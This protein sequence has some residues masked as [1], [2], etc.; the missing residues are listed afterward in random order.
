VE[1]K[2]FVRRMGA[3]E[4]ERERVFRELLPE[5]ERRVRGVCWKQGLRSHES[6]DD[7]L[8]MTVMAMLTHWHAYRGDGSL[9]GWVSRI[10]SNHAVDHHR[11]SAK[12][13]SLD[14]LD[15]EAMQGDAPPASAGLR[16]DIE[17]R[18]AFS[19]DPLHRACVDRVMSELAAEPKARS[20]AVRTEDLLN[21]V[22]LA[23]PDT[24]ELAGFLGTS[25]SGAKER[26]RYALQK[27]SEL[28]RTHCGT[29]DCS[30]SST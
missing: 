9:W 30:W 22:A 12:L 28:C 21:F 29:D 15:D 26:K 6:I 19:A 5:L 8:Q 3:G 13:V 20:G 2:E 25:E 16:A 14:G 17:Q 23:S 7:A 27:L 10:A 18:T 11:E 1:G 4:A 24:A